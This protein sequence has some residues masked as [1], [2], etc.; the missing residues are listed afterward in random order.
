MIQLN[1]VVAALETLCSTLLDLWRRLFYHL[2]DLEGHGW[3]FLKDIGRISSKL[4][5]TIWTL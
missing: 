5:A 3:P 4:V 1:E 2:D